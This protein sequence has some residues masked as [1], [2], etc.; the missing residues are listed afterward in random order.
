MVQNSSRL[1]R[2][3]AETGRDEPHSGVLLV[4]LGAFIDAGKIQRLLGDHLAGTCDAEVL[5]SFDI[6]RLYD[7]RGRRPVMV[8]DSS[9]WASYETPSLQ[10]RRLVDRD[11][12]HYFL[13]SGPEPDFQWERLVEE[14]RDLIVELGISLV[15]TVH[16][17]PMSV[18]HTRPVG[19]TAHATDVAL[20]GDAV[21][22]FGR[23]QVPASFGALLEFRLGEAGHKAA[24]F[25]I[26]VPHYLAASEFAEGALTAL[27]A[28]VD[29]TGLN[30]PNDDLVT[31]AKAN[32]RAID[33]EVEGNEEIRAVL[34]ALEQQ[35][36]A[37]MRGQRSPNLWAAQDS[38]IPSAEQLGADFED[39]LRSV[40]DD[41]TD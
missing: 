11:G 13:L 9:R 33:A 2:I 20:I 14:V 32:R 37:F 28:V 12:D 15:V 8:F 10:L 24:G 25:A 26:H 17:V 22:P 38:E 29:L 39:F 4:T 27:N 19:M 1:Y 16:G 3:E 31:G 6:D 21:S 40:S 5:A 34:E 18:P 23:V 35:Y 41:D 7:Y 30:L 36:D